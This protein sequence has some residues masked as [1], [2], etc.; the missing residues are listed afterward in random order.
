M[1]NFVFDHIY[2]AMPKFNPIVAEG[3][4]VREVKEAESYV[5]HLFKCAQESFPPGLTYDGYRIATPSAEYA[6]LSKKRHGKQEYEFARSDVFMAEYQLSLNGRKLTPQRLLLPFTGETP[7]I[8]IRGSKFFISPVLA[9]VGLSVGVNSIFLPLNRDKLTFER[10]AHTYLI[11]DVYETDYVYWSDI[12][13]LVKQK[14]TAGQAIVPADVRTPLYLYMFCKYGFLE[15]FQ[16]LFG[17]EVVFGYVKDLTP[18]L[19]KEYI[20]CTST[21]KRPAGIKTKYYQASNMYVGVKTEGLSKV[22]STAL[23]T[24]FYLLDY[25]PDRIKPDNLDDTRLWKIVLGQIIFKNRA[26]IGKIIENVDTHLNSVNGYLDDMSKEALQSA[27][28]EVSNI[29]EVFMYIAANFSFILSSVDVASMYDKRLTVNRYLLFDIN[30][31]ISNLVFKLQTLPPNKVVP[32][33][34]EN[35]LARYLKQDIIYGIVNAKHGEVSGMS[36]P[37]D[38]KIFKITSTLVLQA[39][40]NGGRGKKNG[41]LGDPARRFHASIC[42]VGSTTN[43]PKSEPTGRTKINMFVKIDKD[44]KIIRDERKRE[45]IDDIQAKVGRR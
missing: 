30:K 35:I 25:F 1:D 42:E 20:I 14:P 17:T 31:A 19:R 7:E 43:Q 5:E 45:L 11:D 37:G 10:T 9:D 3:Y 44:G 29:Y 33:T 24:F 28:I 15:T 8:N 38:N 40:A 2:A 39:E 41:N 16:T 23:A 21:G 36:Y 32:D 6:A 22:M 26:N 12:H 18:K 13:H 34:V 4:A 27:G